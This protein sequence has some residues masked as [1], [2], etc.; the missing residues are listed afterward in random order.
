MGPVSFFWKWTGKGNTQNHNK[1]SNLAKVTQYMIILTKYPWIVIK[2]QVGHLF[3]EGV[4]WFQLW[5]FSSKEKHSLGPEITTS[6]YHP[7]RWPKS[8]EMVYLY[9]CNTT[10][11]LVYSAKNSSTLVKSQ[12]RLSK[13]YNCTCHICVIIILCHGLINYALNRMDKNRTLLLLIPFGNF[14]ALRKMSTPTG[15]LL[16]GMQS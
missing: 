7:F 2:P 14:N 15:K 10:S 8:I 11:V 9:T 4:K 6:K 13:I 12:T 1:P 5:M 16:A 3:Q